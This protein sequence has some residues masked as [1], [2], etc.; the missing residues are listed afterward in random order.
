[1]AAP[2]TEYFYRYR[3]IERVLDGDHELENQEIYFS[4]PDEL[5]DP[6]DGFKDLFWLG[7][8]IVWR[9]LLKHYV[10]CLLQTAYLCFAAADQFDPGMLRNIIFNMPDAFKDAPIRSIY[11]RIA[12]KFLGEKAVEMFVSLMAV[13]TTPLRRNELTNYLRG[14]HGLATQIIVTD[15]QE[16]G[17]LP[18]FLV[19]FL[20]NN[21]VDSWH[22][23][24]THRACVGSPWRCD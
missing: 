12:A 18:E 9:N 16:R 17:L 15:L 10:L 1:M 3:P 24:R 5:N 2:M 23:Q 7:D 13:R 22:M 6:M 8:E 21:H 19:M 4:T 11:Q 20:T 14:L